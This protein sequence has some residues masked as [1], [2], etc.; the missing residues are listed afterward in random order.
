MDYAKCAWTADLWTTDAVDWISVPRSHPWFLYLAYTSPHAGS[1]GTAPPPLLPHAHTMRTKYNTQYTTRARAQRIA[2]P[3]YLRRC[4][5][6]CALLATATCSTGSIQETDV[7]VPRVGE[8]P[9]ASHRTSGDWPT[10]EV[11]FATAVTEVDA[12]VGKVLDALE[13]THQ[14]QNTVVFFSSE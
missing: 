1:V 6:A 7:P 8:G 2:C 11:N 3:R 4:V 13:T 14:A 10:V 12:A 9:Y 5:R